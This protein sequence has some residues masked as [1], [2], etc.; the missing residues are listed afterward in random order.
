MSLWS[1]L[2]GRKPINAGLNR[3]ERIYLE[4]ADVHVLRSEEALAQRDL[5][6]A[7]LEFKYAVIADNQAGHATITLE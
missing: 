1:K 2:F 4:S 3:P 7:L 5:E 6:K